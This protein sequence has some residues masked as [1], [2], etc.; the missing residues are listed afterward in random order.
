MSFLGE[1]L[2]GGGGALLGDMFMPGI[3]GLVGGYLGNRLAGGNGVLGL[4]GGLISPAIRGA[5]QA[6]F[7]HA[8]DVFQSYLKDPERPF[9]GINTP[10]ESEVW[11]SVLGKNYEPNV[12]MMGGM[13]QAGQVAAARGGTDMS[14]ASPLY[15]TADTIAGYYGGNAAEGALGGLFSG[16]AAEG[17]SGGGIADQGIGYAGL[18]AAGA[19]ALGSEGYSAGLGGLGSFANQGIG[20]AGLDSFG[21]QSL[22]SG[23]ITSGGGGWM[24]M[25]GGWGSNSKDWMNKILKMTGGW[26]NLSR[27]G[28]GLYGFNRMQAAKRAA[29]APID[30]NSS[31][32]YK[33]ALDAAHR[34]SI[35][36]GGFGSGQMA[37]AASAVGP[38]IYNQIWQRQQAQAGGQ[39]NADLAGVLMLASMLGN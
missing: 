4:A 11:G 10:F 33:A 16:G 7:I 12:T 28:L 18:D 27:M 22:G 13:T 24:D 30:V 31:P 21:A 37:A 26:K 2:G 34:S 29:N 38:Q 3:G 19:S 23:P 36:S 25:F 1:L 17:A 35:A 8:G 15:K 32:E 5:F 39:G 20:Y 6:P 9:L 14:L